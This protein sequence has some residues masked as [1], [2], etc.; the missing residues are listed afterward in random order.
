MKFVISALL[1]GL[2]SLASASAC[3]CVPET[4][5]QSYEN[6]EIVFSGHVSE[7]FAYPTAEEIQDKEFSEFLVTF[8][9]YRWWK[10]ER[11]SKIE[12]STQADVDDCGYA[13]RVDQAYLVFVTKEEE[14]LIVKSC[15][16]TGLLENA[17]D[18]IAEL[19]ALIAE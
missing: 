13:F 4:L 16:P 2:I 7:L 1:A 17:A 11:Q 19:D 5:E 9:T 8:T 12:V 14:R 3:E 10:G 18:A 15:G 6:A